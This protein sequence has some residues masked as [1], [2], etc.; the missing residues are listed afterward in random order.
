VV[1]RAFRRYNLQT[2]LHTSTTTISTDKR[3]D[4]SFAW[5]RTDGIVSRK[6]RRSSHVRMKSASVLC[7]VDFAIL[8]DFRP[9][10]Y[11]SRWFRSN[12]TKTYS[13]WLSSD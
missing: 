4:Y 10:K 1:A 3:N 13:P 11:A 8:L 2:N 6:L 5:G 9:R 12:F 7:R